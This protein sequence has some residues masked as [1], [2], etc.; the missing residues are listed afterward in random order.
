MKLLSR[1]PLGTRPLKATPSG[2]ILFF[3][4]TQFHD[5]LFLFKMNWR[6]SHKSGSECSCEI[7]FESE[8]N[9]IRAMVGAK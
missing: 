8:K 4:V 5:N 1:N 3:Q 9:T 7:S 6:T 2:V